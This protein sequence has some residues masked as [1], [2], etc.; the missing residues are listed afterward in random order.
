VRRTG[1]DAAGNVITQTDPLTRSTVYGYDALD[2]VNTQTDPLTRTTV[3]TYDLAGNRTSLTDALHR[4]TTRDYDAGNELR[5]IGYSDGT[6]P[7]VAIT[8]TATGQRAGMS[9]GTG[10]STYSYD[11]LDRVITSTNGAG[12]RLGYGYDAAGRLTT[13][14]YP[15]TS[16]VTHCMVAGS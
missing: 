13:L 5:S 1:Y 2:R 10:A 8:Y 6:T 4:T 15:D 3:Y 11:L 12:Q 16:V 9:D 7:N 14:T